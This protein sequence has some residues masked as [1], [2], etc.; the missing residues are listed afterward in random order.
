M[1]RLDEVTPRLR[2]LSC[3][4]VTWFSYDGRGKNCNEWDQLSSRE[5]QEE[6][7]FLPPPPLLFLVFTSLGSLYRLRKEGPVYYKHTIS[8]L[9]RAFSSLIG[10]PFFS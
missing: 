6:S 2:A 3:F 5:S 10:A 4:F 7:F 1:V 9:D 8:L